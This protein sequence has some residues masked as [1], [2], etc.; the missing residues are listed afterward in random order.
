VVSPDDWNVLLAMRAR[1]QTEMTTVRSRLEIAEAEA[2]TARDLKH[3]LSL[4]TDELSAQAQDRTRLAAA[5]DGRRSGVSTAALR[6]ELGTALAA[7][8]ERESLLRESATL[9]ERCRG[10]IEAKDTELAARSSESAA[11]TAESAAL[12]AELSLRRAEVE[13]QATEL[14]ALRAELE[15]L[16]TEVVSQRDAVADRDATIAAQGD[17]VT[18]LGARL[19][20]AEAALE[21]ARSNGALA[22]AELV[23]ANEKCAALEKIEARCNVLDALVKRLRADLGHRDEEIAEMRE[24]LGKMTVDSERL[25]D[26]WRERT[27]AL[28]QR[29]TDAEAVRTELESARARLAESAL[30]LAA[31]RAE[32]DTANHR[33]EDAERR[34]ATLAERLAHEESRSER[35]RAELESVSER[36]GTAKS[37]H[38][39]ALEAAVHQQKLAARGVERTSLELAAMRDRLES[40]ENAHEREVAALSAE[41]ENLEARLANALGDADT[42]DAER[43]AAVAELGV[44]RSTIAELRMQVEALMGMSGLGERF[45]GDDD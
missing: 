4:A 22:A 32:C 30:T 3:R 7:V 35:F 21:F 44:A 28:E 24:R 6:A 25:G 18:E 29:V 42:I 36:F 5:G 9:V 43:H 27:E 16:R 40:Q 37:V 39:E 23:T 34:V 14:V 17:E 8:R 15:S 31:A 19:T 33:F 12:S 10:E 41:A 38:T 2:R 45:C 1:W 11:K 20:D 13:K 26:D